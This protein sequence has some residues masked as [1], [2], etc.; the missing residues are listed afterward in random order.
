MWIKD[1]RGNRYINMDTIA[2]FGTV[3]NSG[4]AIIE[5]ETSVG[6]NFSLGTYASETRC[7]EILSEI[8]MVL[9]NE[10][11]TTEVFDEKSKEMLPYVGMKSSVYIMPQE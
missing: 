2:D 8:E 7:L 3:V 1:Q 4:I 10:C 5:A 9:Q 6:K 11:Y